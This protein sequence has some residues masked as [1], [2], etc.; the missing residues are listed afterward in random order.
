MLGKRCFLSYLLV[1]RLLEGIPT[2]F[3]LDPSCNCYFRFD[4]EGVHYVDVTAKPD[5]IFTDP[6][7]NNPNVWVLCE[8][9]PLS[10]LLNGNRDWFFVSASQVND[11]GA[12]RERYGI[13]VYFMD[14]W[15]WEEIVSAIPVDE[16][17]FG[18]VEKVH[19]LYQRYGGI[20]RLVL[21]RLFPK[22]KDPQH[23]RWRRLVCAYDA[24]LK[25]KAKEILLNAP[26]AT[27]LGKAWEPSS[28]LFFTVRPYENTSAFE[29]PLYGSPQTVPFALQWRSTIQTAYQ[30]RLLGI[31]CD[32]LSSQ[33]YV[34]FLDTLI[35]EEYTRP[36]AQWVFE[37]LA[38]S[39]LSEGGS[40]RI[41]S[42]GKAIAERIEFRITGDSRTF[43]SVSNLRD[44]LHEL[45][46]P[47]EENT[48]AA[49]PASIMPLDEE[50]LF[51]KYL[52]I[53][54]ANPNAP[55]GLVLVPCGGG[56]DPPVRPLFFRFAS[57]FD[58]LTEPA[59]IIELL[60][61][62]PTHLVDFNRFAP[63]LISV[64]PPVD[65]SRLG[66]AFEKKEVD[67]RLYKSWPRRGKQW[68]LRLED[69]FT[70]WG[71]RPVEGDVSIASR[72]G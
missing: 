37:G 1:I 46:P 32:S 14:I 71:A 7:D 44:T 55:K 2:I 6:L 67:L 11:Y 17:S 34:H 52:H 3:Q 23:E 72:L 58:P 50:S 15:S 65:R 68:I 63:F 45:Y 40:F 43:P 54:S 66:S 48:P 47:P 64:H 41:E 13:P 39:R 70:K 53:T 22:K 28:H 21:Q 18:T 61:A 33:A 56:L 31:V 12:W 59:E 19:F 26:L 42:L 20:P 5:V 9:M 30:G 51:H 57:W 24:E 16:R 35:L 25:A 29:A 49:T 62:I 60:Q 69:R 27:S 10:R 8:G 38:H 36:A 4:A